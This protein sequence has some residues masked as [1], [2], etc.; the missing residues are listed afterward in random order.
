MFF[1]I[2]LAKCTCLYQILDPGTLQ[3]WGNNVYHVVLIFITLFIRVIGVILSVS[4]VYCWTENMSLIIDCVWRGIV[5]LYMCYP[6]WVIV[7]YSNDIWNCLSIVC[8]GF[9]SHSLRD[10]YNILDRWREWYVLLTTIL[11]VTY[12]TAVVDYFVSSLAIHYRLKIAMIH[13][14]ITVI[15]YS[16]CIFYI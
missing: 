16:I 8:Y 15:T 6:M 7:H 14:A 11:T 2:T 3:F 1:N 10:R 9:K 5:S 4:G 12:F 13:S